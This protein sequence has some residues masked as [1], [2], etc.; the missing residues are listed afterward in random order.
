M[1]STQQA[2]RQLHPHIS[3]P[4]HVTAISEPVSSDE[5][6]FMQSQTKALC[7]MVHGDLTS[8]GMH[9]IQPAALVPLGSH[10]RGSRSAGRTVQQWAC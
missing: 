2:L 10:D 3:D 6:I 9:M 4:L 1:A 8:G 7:S 5:Q